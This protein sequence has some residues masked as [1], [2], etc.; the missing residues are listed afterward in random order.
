MT[1]SGS[2]PGSGRTPRGER[3]SSSELAAALEEFGLQQYARPL[4]ELGFSTV[5]AILR[6]PPTKF[7]GII[8][9]LRPLPG[10]TV[11]LVNAVEEM[12]SRRIASAHAHHGST[13]SP[14]LPSQGTHVSTSSAGAKLPS[15]AAERASQ[16]ARAYAKPPA[17][18]RSRRSGPSGKPPRPREH[19]GSNPRVPFAQLPPVQAAHTR[20]RHEHTSAHAQLHTYGGSSGTRMPVDGEAAA[21]AHLAALRALE[22]QLGVLHPESFGAV[23]ADVAPTAPELGLQK[24]EGLYSMPRRGTLTPLSEEPAEEEQDDGDGDDEDAEAEERTAYPDHSPREHY[25]SPKAAAAEPSTPPVP[26]QSPAASAEHATAANEQAQ[27]AGVADGASESLLPPAHT[28]SSPGV[29]PLPSASPDVRARAPSRQRSARSASAAGLLANS[30]DGGRLLE[31]EAEGSIACP[32]TT[33]TFRCVSLVLHKHICDGA[34]AL[35][36]L[37]GGG[38]RTPSAGASSLGS[39]AAHT[40]NGSGSGSAAA[41]ADASE[42][43]DAD[44]DGDDGSFYSDSFDSDDDADAKDSSDAHT[45]RTSQLAQIEAAGRPPSPL[46]AQ[47]RHLLAARGG[48]GSG[49]E[50]EEVDLFSSDSDA[51]DANGA[52]DSLESV[53]PEHDAGASGADVARAGTDLDEVRALKPVPLQMSAQSPAL[54]AG[55][56]IAL[57]ASVAASQGQPVTFEPLLSPVHEG[58]VLPGAGETD[59]AALGASE[60]WK[61][62]DA[63]RAPEGAETIFDEAQHPLGASTRTSFALPSLAEVANFVSNVCVGT[64]MGAETN[65]VGLAYIERLLSTGRVQLGAHTWRRIVLAAWLLAGKMW[66]DDS[67]DNREFARQF[68]LFEKDINELEAAFLRAVGYDLSLSPSAYARYYFMLRALSQREAHDFPLR[69]LDERIAWRC[70]ASSKQQRLLFGESAASVSVCASLEM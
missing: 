12:R 7:D 43:S 54:A 57:E 34:H 16:I 45:A 58:K 63:W 23:A 11:R 37:S 32:N 19:S 29:E 62:A 39:T 24:L 56:R 42:S 4:A 26:G 51:S 10:H 41:S 8:T 35:L 15:A 20:G 55:T 13:P 59:A 21:L 22:D 28:P 18:A 25:S 52:A 33:E 50:A 27:E 14:A 48:V 61:G 60:L 2:R 9:T 49:A 5:S 40:P 30:F 68:L 64:R 36:L 46:P 6:V 67:F 53:H 38:S 69:P 65:I 3:P 1:A 44:E 47:R 17:R 66:D 31:V 70:A